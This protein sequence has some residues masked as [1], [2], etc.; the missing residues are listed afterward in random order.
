MY[1]RVRVDL[2]K[3]EENARRLRSFLQD[4]GIETVAVTKVFGA[5]E[6]ILD[7]YGRGGIKAFADARLKNLARIDPARGSRLLLRIPMLEELDDVLSYADCSLQSDLF[8]LTELNRR[9]RAR[10]LRHA[11]L[12][13]IDLGDLR[14]GVF[15]KE[16]LQSMARAVLKLDAIDWIGT[17]T[18]LTCYGGI[19]PSEENLTRLLELTTWLREETGLALP[20]ISAGNSSSLYLTHG[21]F[22]KGLNHLR[23]G[24]ALV[25]GTEAA[26]G[27][28]FHSLHTDSFVME[29]QI[30]E[31]R[32]KP[33]VPIGEIGKNAFGE[34]PEFQDKG[35]RVR[36]IAAIGRQDVDPS[37]LV[38][39]DPKIEI[40]GASSDHMIL[41]VTD[42]DTPYRTGDI[43]SFAMN[44]RAILRTF[45]SEYVDRVFD[46]AE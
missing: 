43:V 4:K 40:L 41:D 19:L 9:A 14:E 11:I 25:L 22:P 12:L 45:T 28:R 39:T 46:G 13:M 17:G 27:Q 31:C 21:D 37:D 3:L 33:S 34:T 44:Y 29:T 1:P 35:E 36:A 5:D 8:T 10:G 23:I 30:V 15:D 7:A 24:E 38:P 18:N 16:E 2:R 6:H 26:Y 32:R 42:S 20:V